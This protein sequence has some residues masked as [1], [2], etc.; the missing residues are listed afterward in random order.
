MAKLYECD[1][2]K[3]QSNDPLLLQ[4]KIQIAASDIDEETKDYDICLACTDLLKQ[5]LKIPDKEPRYSKG[6]EVKE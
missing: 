3:V 4:A 2:C 6:M 1:R 5:W